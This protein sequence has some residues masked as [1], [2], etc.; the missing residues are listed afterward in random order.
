VRFLDGRA[1]WPAALVDARVE[2]LGA[3][4]LIEGYVHRV[5]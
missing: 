3:D 2:P 5:D 1:F 4:V